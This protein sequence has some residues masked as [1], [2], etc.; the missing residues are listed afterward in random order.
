M[1][2]ALTKSPIQGLLIKVLRSEILVEY[3]I[4]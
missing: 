2:K 1:S 4:F 3:R